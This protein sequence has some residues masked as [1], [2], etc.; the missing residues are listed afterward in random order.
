MKIDPVSLR[1]FISVIEHGT[2]AGAADDSHIAASAVSKRISD[3]E[4]TLN[5]ELLGRTNKGIEPTPA[6]IALM[7]MARTALHE[8]EDIYFQMNEYSAG[9]RGHIRV[10]ANISAIAQ[11]L[12]NDLR[13]FLNT[14]PNVQVKLEE[15]ISVTIV[16]AVIE[17]AADIGIITM[18]PHG[19][20]VETIPYRQDRLCIIVPTTHPLARRKSVRFDETI[21]HIYIGLHAGSTINRQ[22]IKSATELGK[23]VHIRM[24]VTSFYAL[25]RM[26]EAGLGVGMLP[27]RVASSQARALQI[28]VL[29][30]DEPWAERKLNI[31]VRSKVALSPASRLLVQHLTSN[32]PG[33]P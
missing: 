32:A 17:N 10:F 28:K 16:K 29:Y 6:G 25:C 31:C 33:P 22:L 7:N 30:L 20:D 9:V 12:P 27:E 15:K 13:S 2:I 26:I 24:E 3:L 1:L 5:I 19:Y 14:Y 4:S 21:E 18:S 8:L 11:F 23:T